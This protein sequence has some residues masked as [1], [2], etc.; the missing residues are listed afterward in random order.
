MKVFML[1]FLSFFYTDIH[2]K[3]LALF[4]AFLLWFVGHNLNNP[5]QNSLFNLPLQF[6]NMEILTS[7][8]LVLV[9]E[10][11][12]DIHIQVG[13]RAP[14]RDL[15]ELSDASAAEQLRMVVPSV[16]FR[17]VNIEAVRDSDGPVTVRLAVSVNLDARY[18]HFSINPSFIE[19]ELDV[20]SRDVHTV[21]I[22]VL[23]EVA[24]GFELGQIRLANNNVAVTGS[25][26]ML[27]DVSNV[28]VDVDV[29]GVHSD[30]E[31]PVPLVVL[32]HA[33]EDITEYLQLS[34]R[35]TIATVP[36]RPV[37]ELEIRVRGIGDVAAG[38]ALASE[39][40]VEPSA[41]SV[42]GLPERLQELEYM[43]IEVDLNSANA[44]FELDANVLDWLPDGILLSTWETEQVTM[45]VY[46]EPIEI[47]AF[48][49]PSDNVRIR[50]IAALYEILS[51]NATIRVDVSGPRTLI[52]TLNNTQIGLEL[53]L[54]NLPIGV[55]NVTL[56]VS[57]PE[58]M[59]R[60]FGAPSLQVQ[61]HEPA[62]IDDMD[63]YDN[64]YN[65]EDYDDYAEQAPT[66]P[67]AP[68]VGG[69]DEDEYRE[70]ED[71]TLPEYPPSYDAYEY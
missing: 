30:A 29:L 31:I 33:G 27:R 17:A 55:H 51:G 16:D 45:Y 35:E 28:S 24:P 60:A 49:V 9:N 2:W 43:Y 67:A 36:V 53:D 19:I 32:N 14:R 54:R 64:N 62:A 56:S 42:T 20:I 6:Q 57:L 34:V 40:R 58:G 44:D 23:N 48:F 4:L 70:N 47:R 10:D 1:K 39:I 25:R 63:D 5:P 69:N 37:H 52:S 66:S 13:V 61:I 21:N 41:I 68:I 59:T 71:E 26:T 18:E 12:L 22:N 65:A 8:G 11:A 50:G 7:E 38:F 15:D 46:I 3:L